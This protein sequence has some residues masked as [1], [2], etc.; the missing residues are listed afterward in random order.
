MSI[1][2]YITEPNSFNTKKQN[3]ILFKAHDSGE[4]LGRLQIESASGSGKTHI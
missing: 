1:R 3:Q 4:N 2:T